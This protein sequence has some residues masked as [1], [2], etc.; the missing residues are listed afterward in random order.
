MI[1]VG[2]I[3]ATGYAGVELVRIILGHPQ[4]ELSA[5]GSVSFTGK[6]LSDV[7]P[8][9]ADCCDMELVSTEEVITRSDIVFACVQ[10][11]LSQEFAAQ[12]HEKKVKF[13]DLGA[14]FRLEEEADYKAWYGLDYTH[15]ELHEEAVYALPELYRDKIKGKTVLGNPGC[16]PTSIA[17]GLAPAMKNHLG[18]TYDT[19]KFSFL[20]VKRDIIEYEQI[21]EFLCQIRNLY[22]YIIFAHSSRLLQCVIC[23]I[24]YPLSQFQKCGIYIV[25]RSGKIHDVFLLDPRRTVCQ[26]DDPI[27]KIY[28]FLDIVCHKNNSTLFFLPDF[29]QFLFHHI[30]CLRVQMAKRLIQQH[31]FRIVTVGSGNPYSLAHSSR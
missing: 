16:Y 17:L 5:V 7:Y 13:I 20:Y 10:H 6:K 28:R 18:R 29:F 21:S 22:F 2:I 30:S 14:D 11:G 12:C 26:K 1:K 24:Q 4:A 15:H 3:G 25:P 19:E 23:I 27:C 31:D 9:L 8:S